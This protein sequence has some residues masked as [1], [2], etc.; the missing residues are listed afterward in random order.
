MK[1]APPAMKEASRPGHRYLMDSHFVA[2]RCSSGWLTNKCQITAH[3]PSVCGVMRSGA[4]V[5]MTTQLP[6]DLVRE[7]A[8]RAPRCRT[9]ERP[10]ETAVSSARTMFTDT[11][12]STLPPPTENT[13]TASRGA[14]PRAFQPARK[15]GL[16]A[17]VI[18]ARREFGH[19]VGGGVSFKAAELAKIVHRVAGVAGR[20][21]HAQD[22]Q[23]ST[24]LAHLGQPPGHMLN[25]SGIH[26]F[27][28]G[29]GFG[30]KRG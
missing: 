6:R 17:F 10:R 27:E 3:S 19:V 26:L 5:G 29:D 15:T 13:R 24:A 9:H 4:T 8:V 23:T 14:D 1:P 11:F 16:P 21:S 2:A 22:E 18:G 12:F 20:T 30:Q 28:D 25:L 7:S